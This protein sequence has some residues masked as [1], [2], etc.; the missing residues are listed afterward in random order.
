M[1]PRLQRYYNSAVIVASRGVG[2][3]IVMT[4]FLIKKYTLSPSEFGNL[5]YAYA[6]AAALLM[7][8]ASPMVMI[9]SRRIIQTRDLSRDRWIIAFWACL[10]LVLALIPVVEGFACAGSMSNIGFFSSVCGLLLIVA[11]NGQYV[12]WLNESDHTARSLVFILMFLFSIPLSL[13]VRIITGIGLNDRSFSIETILLCVPVL[14]NCAFAKSTGPTGVADLYGLSAA[15]YAKYFMVV[16][17][18][19]GILWVDWTLGKIFLPTGAYEHWAAV[20]ILMERALLPVLNIAQVALLW[21]LLRSST[22]QASHTAVA[23]SPRAI[24]RF[25]L[26]LA[27]A[28]AVAIT[29]GWL[30]ENATL[31]AAA[32]VSFVMGYLA[33][34]LTSIFLDFYQAKFTV[35]FIATSFLAMTLGRLALVA[36]AL[37]YGSSNLYSVAWSVSSILILVYISNRSW[38]QIKIGGNR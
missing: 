37:E 11:L 27:V 34:G 31:S 1:H 38:D 6:S 23:V 30:A 15:N 19:N 4:L 32:Y 22:G 21:Q 24:A 9:I 33:F 29:S 7:P 16:L 13:G 12:I 36:L 10:A 18:Y 20:R 17:F 8:F 25:Q 2:S 14:V 35:R 26:V 3:V 28:A 5:G